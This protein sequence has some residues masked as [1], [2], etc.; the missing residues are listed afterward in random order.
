M[1][2]F[3]CDECFDTLTI[4]FGGREITCPFCKEPVLDILLR[5]LPHGL[6]YEGG[7][8]ATVAQFSSS[9]LTFRGT[10]AEIVTDVRRVR[11]A[12]EGEAKRRGLSGRNSVSSAAIA[13]EKRVR[14]ALS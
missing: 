6:G 8:Y 4:D 1:S 5:R 3:T 14:E 7:K 2:D 12:A 9:T 13:I 11:L 10:R